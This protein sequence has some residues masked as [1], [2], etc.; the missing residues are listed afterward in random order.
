MYSELCNESSQMLIML[1]RLP[2]DN[3]VPERERLQWKTLRDGF[4]IFRKWTADSA[5]IASA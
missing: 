5:D 1:S 2:G 4:P 3:I